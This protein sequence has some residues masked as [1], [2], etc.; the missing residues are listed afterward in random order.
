LIA[1]ARLLKIGCLLV[2]ASILVLIHWHITRVALNPRYGKIFY[3]L[4]LECEKE[5]ATN[6]RLYYFKRAV[7][8]DPNLS[9]AYYQLGTI[10]GREGR[11]KEEIESYKRN[12]Q[13]DWTNGEAYFK[14]GLDYFQRGEFDQAIRHFLQSDRRRPSAHDTFYYLAQSYDRKGMYPE[15]VYYYVTLIVW[16]SPRSAEICERI[17]SISKIPDQF[18]MVTKQLMMLWN[19][20]AGQYELWKQIDQ[21]IKTDQRPEFMRK[22]EGQVGL[23]N[24]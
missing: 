22:S 2:C 1:R 23:T 16:G 12:V 3:R 14:V 9:D 21:Y 19:G 8:Y 5:C 10:Y 13:L 15:A 6:E 18:Q 24:D 7:F 17:W 11:H 4:G 20:N